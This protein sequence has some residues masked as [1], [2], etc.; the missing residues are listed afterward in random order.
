VNIEE[1]LASA[2]QKVDFFRSRYVGKDDSYDPIRMAIE[3]Q[4]VFESSRPSID[5]VRKLVAIAKEKKNV[6]DIN[7]FT[8]C[9]HME[10]TLKQ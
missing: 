8:F 10:S 5:Q 3:W 1:E 4:K 9:N 6:F 7:Y 2:R